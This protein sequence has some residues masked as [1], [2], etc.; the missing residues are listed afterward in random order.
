MAGLDDVF[1]DPRTAGALV[2]SLIEAQFRNQLQQ[3]DPL[4]QLQQQAAQQEMESARRLEA[5]R[6]SAGNVRLPAPQVQPLQ[7]EALAPYV[8][9]FAL[10][11]GPQG[12]GVRPEEFGALQGLSPTDALV[13]VAQLRE[14]A[15]RQATMPE[16]AIQNVSQLA[17]VLANLKGL[18]PELTSQLIS[19]LT[20]IETPDKLVNQLALAEAKHSL[21]QGQRDIQNAGLRERLDLSQQQ[22]QALMQQ[23]QAQNELAGQRQALQTQTARM[24]TTP[25]KE[26][27]KIL[28]E[29]ASGGA[30][31][32]QM[33]M[34][35]SAMGYDVAGTRPTGGFLGFGQ[36]QTPILGI[37]HPA[38]S[39]P[40]AQTSAPADTGGAM[41]GEVVV[42]KAGKR[43]AV[44]PAKLQ[45]ALKQ[46]YKLVQ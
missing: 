4:R 17:G 16:R 3:A 23:R 10:G 36:T 21:G 46:G 34:A 37:R 7:G 27:N 42:E 25:F 2:S 11:E 20:G 41:Q 33:Q 43:F 6:Q 29:M 24:P 9:Q 22:L 26:A 18:P 35:A 44:S 14:Q 12:A 40:Q 5:Q 28:A 8:K 15:Q 1:L 13:R 38:G 19:R 39:V 32:E 45:A 31:P 30:T